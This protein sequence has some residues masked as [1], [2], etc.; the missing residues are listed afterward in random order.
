MIV[1][2]SIVT[3]SLEHFLTALTILRVST[4]PWSARSATEAWPAGRAWRGTGLRW[5]VSTLLASTSWLRRKKSRPKSKFRYSMSLLYLIN[6]SL[7]CCCTFFQKSMTFKQSIKK[8]P[9]ENCGQVFQRFME[10]AGHLGSI[11][12]SVECQSCQIKL[13]SR[14]Q[15]ARHWMTKG[16]LIPGNPTQIKKERHDAT[17]KAKIVSKRTYCQIYSC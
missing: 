7:K 14:L 9:F 12:D 2:S 3:L 6:P 11:H 8:C 4:R 5:I 16:C 17:S 15:L 13:N 1:P 10:L